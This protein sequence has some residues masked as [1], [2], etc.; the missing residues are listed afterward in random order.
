[1][2]P[3]TAALRMYRSSADG[4][5]DATQDPL[6]SSSEATAVPPPSLPPQPA[7]VPYQTDFLPPPPPV[8]QPPLPPAPAMQQPPLPPPPVPPPFPS[9]A[10]S[11]A[12][13]VPSSDSYDLSSLEREADASPPSWVTS[14]LLPAVVLLLLALLLAIV[15][16]STREKDKPAASDHPPSS[17]SPPPSFVKL[18]WMAERQ[19]TKQDVISIMGADGERAFVCT[20][21][22][23]F[24]E[25]RK[26]R[27]PL[28]R[29]TYVGRISLSGKKEHVCSLEMGG[30]IDIHDEAAHCS[31]LQREGDSGFDAE[32]PEGA[33]KSE[34]AH[35][36]QTS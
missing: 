6:P 15:F 28:Q 34:K 20:A 16:L 8:Q 9:S 35:S 36:K 21:D 2:D 24:A 12:E 17:S 13:S 18:H 14:L 22:A 27:L 30:C 5:Y 7:Y 26:V 23:V 19:P 10:G 3:F 33:C 1:M 29:G 25:H 31:P 11:V 32:V 4:T